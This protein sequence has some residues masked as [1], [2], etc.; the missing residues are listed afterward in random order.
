MVSFMSKKGCSSIILGTQPFRL[1]ATAEMS[2]LKTLEFLLVPFTR[3]PK[4]FHV[5]INLAGIEIC[6]LVFQLV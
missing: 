1:S 3:L 2:V 4:L 6:Q 5:L